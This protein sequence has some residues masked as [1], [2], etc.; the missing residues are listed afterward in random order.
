MLK[1]DLFT[2]GFEKARINC[3]N[4]DYTEYCLNNRG[5][6]WLYTTN[7]FN[8]ILY[9]LLKKDFYCGG[10]Q[11]LRMSNRA[12]QYSHRI[13]SIQPTNKITGVVYKEWE[14]DNIYLYQN[15]YTKTVFNP[16]SGIKCYTGTNNGIIS[17]NYYCKDSIYCVNCD[18]NTGEYCIE[19]RGGRVAYNGVC[20]TFCPGYTIGGIGGE[21]FSPH[22]PYGY[23]KDG[24][25]G[26]GKCVLGD[27]SS[28]G[29]G[30]EW[31]F[32]DFCTICPSPMTKNG[33]YC[34][35]PTH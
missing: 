6:S 22:C 31:I 15:E 34:N 25:A 27:C 12:D 9:P 30:R 2:H 35:C 28:A 8:Q 1:N 17:K 4:G 26:S 16:E 13:F 11:I 21:C 20:V 32:G 29:S 5:R 18:L 24:S 3:L 19:C 10:S 33:S 7:C 14:G 23:Y